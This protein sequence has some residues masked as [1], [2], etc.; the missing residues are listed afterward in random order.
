MAGWRAAGSGAAEAGSLPDAAN[1]EIPDQSAASLY[2][3]I[4]RQ[5]SILMPTPG[6]EPKAEGEL[7]YKRCLI[8]Q[9]SGCVKMMSDDLEWT[10]AFRD[11]LAYQQKYVLIAIQQ[12]REEAVAKGRKGAGGLET[13]SSL[14]QDWQLF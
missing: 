1:L 7:G 12:L 11:A 4:M 14:R 10:Q 5:R 3:L 2:P 8:A 9:L 6:Q 13:S